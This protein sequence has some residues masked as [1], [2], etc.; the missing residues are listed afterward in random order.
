LNR[1]G[2]HFPIDRFLFARNYL[3]FRS[4][5]QNRTRLGFYHFP[6]ERVLYGNQLLNDINYIQSYKIMAADSENLYFQVDPSDILAASDDQFVE[7]QKRLNQYSNPVLM[8]AH[9]K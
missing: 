2:I 3:F 6:T 4:Y 1:L 8:V 9:F 7:L 5:V